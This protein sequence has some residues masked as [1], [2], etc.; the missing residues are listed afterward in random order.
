[1]SDEK[2][3]ILNTFAVDVFGDEQ[4]RSRLSK[5]AYTKMFDCMKGRLSMD[6]TLAE[7][8]ATAMKNWAIERDVTH[9]THWFMPMT[10]ITA[11]KQDSFLELLDDGRAI[12]EFSAKSLIK[13]EPDASSFPSG[14]LRDTHK[15]KAYTAWDCSSPAFIKDHILYIPTT[16][17]SHSGYLLDK[18]TPLLR[19]IEAINN[20]AD[21]LLRL[22]HYND[23]EKI[24]VMVGAE[25]E[26]FLVDKDLFEARDDLR[27][28]NCTL[29][30]SK[31]PKDQELED[32]YLAKIR[33]QV[34]AFMDSLNSKLWRLGIAAKTQ[35]NEVAPSQHELAIIFNT[36]SVACDH[37]QLVMEI[38]T[39]TARE[40]GMECLLHEKPYKGVN[41]SGKHINWSL[42]TD[43][44]KNL[45]RYSSES[46]K[47]VLSFL[48]DEAY[49]D[50]L[51]QEAII[52]LF[53]I[54]SVVKALHTYPELL[55]MSVASLAN[56]KRLGEGEAP[57]A[58]V[59][60]SI[61]ADLE[62]FLKLLNQAFS[63]E[64]VKNNITSIGLDRIIDLGLSTC[65]LCTV[66]PCDRNRTSPFAYTGNKFEFRMPGSSCNI[67]DPCYVLNT[68]VA[69]AM[70]ELGDELETIKISSDD[71]E[72]EYIEQFRLLNDT[73]QKHASVLFDGDNYSDSWPEEAEN[74]GLCFAKD[75]LLSYHYLSSEKAVKLFGK[76]KVLNTKELQA[77]ELILK[78]YYIKQSL[79]EARIMQNLLNKYIIDDCYRYLNDLNDLALKNKKLD[80]HDYHLHEK[81]RFISSKVNKVIDL[82]KDLEDLLQAYL[83]NVKN[84]ANQLSSYQPLDDFNAEVSSLMFKEELQR[85]WAKKIKDIRVFIDEL[86]FNMPKR[87]LSL[88]S[89][90]DLFFKYKYE[91]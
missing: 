29:F 41:G 17:F 30:G 51:L 67:A 44:K 43:N 11:E 65:S 48:N 56:E 21:R 85:Q 8:V 7:E 6:Y 45:F 24:E 39:S 35:H 88:P 20:Q 55:L 38:M 53:C 16:Y 36:A 47:Q 82:Q 89:Y 34:K 1:M 78:E 14:G 70:E 74:R 50:N 3:Q 86:E 80:Y 81:I 19:S 77:R 15:A 32:Q 46:L 59:S 63:N 31:S 5:T 76:Q 37:N 9:Y 33:P 87:Y 2:V 12:L 68:M 73:F 91:K 22:L 72:E 84:D 90:F 25:Q 69:Q 40:Y 13:G 61:G 79:V 62:S 71:R 83:S 49:D 10:G 4:M 64:V 18:K 66:D 27:A 58:I 26:Y 28:C 54:A 60:M 57:P 23:F 52:F 75:T 42:S